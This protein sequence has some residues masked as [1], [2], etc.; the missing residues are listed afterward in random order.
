M[1]ASNEPMTD[2]ALAQ[3]ALQRVES[4]Q[5]S[6][7]HW[8][9]AS[10]CSALVDGSAS[11]RDWN[12]LWESSRASALE[13]WNAYQV[14]GD[15]LRGGVPLAAVTPAATFLVNFQ[16]RI[17][18]ELSAATRRPVTQSVAES[19]HSVDGRHKTPANDALFRWK[20]L[21]T[22][23]SISAVMAVSWAVLGTV[24]GDPA[25]Q[26]GTE[27]AMTAPPAPPAEG[28]VAES[29]NP[30]S[31][32]IVN[33]GQGPLIRDARL[34]ALLAEHRQYGGLSALQ[35]PAGFLRNATY[36]APAR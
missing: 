29:A 18:Q 31:A 24:T 35:K 6:P 25:S 22:A 26:R 9:D 33:T 7:D 15:A 34:E 11:E 17:Q 30:D 12:A 8:E 13:D 27:M 21:A 3:Q 4:S 36:D 10:A 2:A 32:V 28:V 14:V 1:K 16:A 5:A 23:A 20:M 19:V